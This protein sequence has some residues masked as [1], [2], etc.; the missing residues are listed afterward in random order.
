M[1]FSMLNMPE[2]ASMYM[3]IGI[4]VEVLLMMD[5]F[6]LVISFLISSKQRK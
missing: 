2:F 3:E 4:Q 1:D 6:K 5:I